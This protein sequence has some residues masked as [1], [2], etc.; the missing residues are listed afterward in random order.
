[1]F[2]R[3]VQ[4]QQEA[5][6]K[7]TTEGEVDAE[8][9]L[10][11]G[12][13]LLNNAGLIPALGRVLSTDQLVRHP[14]RTAQE[15]RPGSS[16]APGPVPPGLEATPHLP[17][18]LPLHPNLQGSFFQHVFKP[19]DPF[20]VYI[21][22]FLKL[23][24]L[25]RTGSQKGVPSTPGGG[26]SGLSLT[27]EQTG[28]KRSNGRRLTLIFIDNS[29]LPRIV[30]PSSISWSCSKIK[31]NKV[32]RCP[33]THRNILLFLGFI[34]KINIRNSINPKIEYININ[35]SISFAGFLFVFNWKHVPPARAG[36]GGSWCLIGWC[37][38]WSALVIGGCE[39]SGV[40]WFLVAGVPLSSGVEPGGRL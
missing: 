14:Q 1:M 7:E 33:K 10:G 37:R 23:T 8:G 27:I 17:A 29:L 25:L 26:K 32:T 39:R 2:A 22:R 3:T 31:H 20:A 15:G 38:S 30:L 35:I 6:E 11:A 21:G 13:A 36:G 34:Y 18:H 9:Q 19:T 16:W 12:A 40:T 4:S 28:G 24:A 5:S